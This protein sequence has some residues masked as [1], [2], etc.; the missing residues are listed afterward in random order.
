MSALRLRMTRKPGS[1]TRCSG[2]QASARRARRRQ[3]GEL[4]QLVEPPVERRPVAR[5]AA[6]PRSRSAGR[7]RSD[8]ARRSGRCP[9]TSSSRPKRDTSSPGSSASSGLN[10]S[11]PGCS[12][13]RSSQ[14][15]STWSRP[16]ARARGQLS[17][18]KTSWRTARGSFSAR[19]TDR[20]QDLGRR[21][22][23]SRGRR[24]PR[25]GP[26]AASRGQRFDAARLCRSARAGRARGAASRVATVSGHSCRPLLGDV[27]RAD[28][29]GDVVAARVERALHAVEHGRRAS[30]RPR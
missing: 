23:G 26:A 18:R 1:S 5:C 20:L 9:A 3:V 25:R 27:G 11:V 28:A 21:G 16:T 22:A 8:R 15:T 29:A 2:T 13:P 30:D 4:R 24:R 6:L 7:R 17:M 19:Q 10:E 12:S 14:P